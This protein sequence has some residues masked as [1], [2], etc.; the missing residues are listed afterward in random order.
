MN[1]PMICFILFLSQ[2]GQLF[3]ILQSGGALNLLFSFSIKAQE[4][5]RWLNSAL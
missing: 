2:I 1:L 5:E 4:L 3:H